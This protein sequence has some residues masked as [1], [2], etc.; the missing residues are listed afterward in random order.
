[1]QF[2]GIKTS[3]IFG[4]S[5]RKNLRHVDSLLLPVQR[6]F[7][8][9]C[10]SPSPRHLHL[11]P[12]PFR[13]EPDAQLER[14][15]QLGTLLLD[16]MPHDVPCDLGVHLAAV[17]AHRSENPSDLLLCFREGCK[18]FE[19]CRF[20][21]PGTPIFQSALA[22]WHS[23]LSLSNQES[24]DRHWGG[25]PPTVPYRYRSCDLSIKDAFLT[26]YATLHDSTQHSAKVRNLQKR[27]KSA[28]FRGKWRKFQLDISSAEL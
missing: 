17:I 12:Q 24:I 20:A 8:C 15:Q 18:R 4:N 26:A 13:Y 7:G 25:Q 16:D 28:V 23:L 2:A 21:T 6:Q 11:F 10:C 5:A 22:L 14:F 27:A 19:T 3:K 1:V 9:C